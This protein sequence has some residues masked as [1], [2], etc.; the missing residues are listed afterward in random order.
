VQKKSVDIGGALSSAFSGPIEED[1]APINVLAGA[2]ASHRAQGK[3]ALED[4]PHLLTVREAVA[5]LRSGTLTPEDYYLEI[6]RVHRQISDLMGLFEMPQVQRELARADEPEQVLAEKTHEHLEDIEQALARLVNFL[7]SQE[8]A[9]LAEGLAQL[10]AGYLAL[11]Q[12]QDEALQMAEDCDEDDF[13][14]GDV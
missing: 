7:D 13:E 5:G 9:D 2:L 1:S 4:S 12:T 14:E 11:D 8:P 3:G 10:E 6:S